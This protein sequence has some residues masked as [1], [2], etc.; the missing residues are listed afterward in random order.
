MF[1]KIWNEKA[2]ITSEINK[3][4]GFQNEEQNDGEIMALLHSEISE[5]F[6]AVRHGNPPSDKIPAFSGVEEELADTVI[7]IMNYGVL[8]GFHIAEAIEAKTLFNAQRSF[9][10]GGKTC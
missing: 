7:R 5:A 3:A 6:E 2:I 10:H 9:K 8:R 4:K 1:Q